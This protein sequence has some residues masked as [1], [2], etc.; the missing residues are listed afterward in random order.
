[1]LVSFVANYGAESSCKF[2]LSTTKLPPHES[3]VKFAEHDTVCAKSLTLKLVPELSCTVH[4]ASGTA[5][6]IYYG[7]IME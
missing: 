4:T 7:R 1:M 6:Y 5:T 3:A 2:I